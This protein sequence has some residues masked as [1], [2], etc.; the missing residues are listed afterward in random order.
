MFSYLLKDSIYGQD[1][2]QGK[3]RDK[4]LF[5]SDFAV[6]LKFSERH[7]LIIFSLKYDRA[8]FVSSEKFGVNLR[9]SLRWPIYIYIYVIYYQYKTN[10]YCANCL[11]CRCPRKCNSG[12]YN[13]F[14]FK[15]RGI[16]WYAY[17][18]C[19]LVCMILLAL[20]ICLPP[21]IPKKL[22]ANTQQYYFPRTY[23]R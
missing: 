10:L 9:N 15:H 23:A 13:N 22:D 1:N 21:K 18:F 2:G 11:P 20:K 4:K 5:I 17:L 3:G 14:E 12:K 8:Y 7:F 16:T 6:G 19:L